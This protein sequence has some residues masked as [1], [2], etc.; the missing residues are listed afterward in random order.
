MNECYPQTTLNPCCMFKKKKPQAFNL[1]GRCQQGLLLLDNHNGMFWRLFSP[2]R[3][4][5]LTHTLP[6]EPE[7]RLKQCLI[8]FYNPTL[9]LRWRHAGRHTIKFLMSI[10]DM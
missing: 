5:Q 10:Q 4:T 1:S 3:H 8:C 7:K 6:A 2:Y 9:R